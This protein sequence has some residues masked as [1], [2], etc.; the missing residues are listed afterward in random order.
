MPLDFSAILGS[1]E[2]NFVPPLMSCLSLPGSGELSDS[3]PSPPPRYSKEKRQRGGPPPP[4]LF[5]LPF[6]PE[7]EG[8]R[9]AS[10]NLD[11]LLE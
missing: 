4:L 2:L 7:K 3:L 9:P 10:Y 1:R 8:I 6:L 5:I 11:C